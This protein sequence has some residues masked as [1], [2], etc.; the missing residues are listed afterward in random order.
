M[1]KVF[2]IT[3]HQCKT[4]RLGYGSDESIH[5]AERQAGFLAS[6]HDYTPTVSDRTVNSKHTI[7]ESQGQLFN[8]PLRKPLAPPTNGHQL[9]SMADLRKRNHTDEYPVLINFSQPRNDVAVRLRLHPF[10]NY[11]GIK[12]KVHSSMARGPLLVR[13]T[14]S[15]E[16]RSGDAAKN[17]ARLPARLVLRCHSSADT[18]TTVCLPLRVMV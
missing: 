4:M 6:R 15:P 10:R 14:L 18:T 13:L 2:D 12:Q 9:D 7:F 17:S 3:C 5:S 1:P 8:Q 11:I 16:P